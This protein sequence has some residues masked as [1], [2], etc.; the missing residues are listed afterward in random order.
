[1]KPQVTDSKTNIAGSSVI[2]LTTVSNEAN[3]CL[4]E[5]LHAEIMNYVVGKNSNDSNLKEGE[6]NLSELE[7][8]GFGVGYRIIERLTREWV[9]FKDELDM[10]KFICT[11]YWSSLYQKQIDNLKTNHHGTYVLQDNEFRLLKHLANNTS[12]NKQYL[13]ECPRLISF[14]CGLLRG[15]LAN[16]GISSIVKAEITLIPTCKFHVEVQRV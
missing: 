6:E 15:S 10:I 9:R 8:M 2:P 14:T 13:R 5:Y 1:M 12:N 16:L 3:E 11:D 4:F 7:W